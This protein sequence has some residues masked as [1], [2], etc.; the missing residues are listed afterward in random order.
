MQRLIQ[1]VYNYASNAREQYLLLKLYRNAL[2]TEVTNRVDQIRQI[3]TGNP[4]FIKLVV[5]QYRDETGS[6]YVRQ[7]L[8]GFMKDFL[9]RGSMD[10]DSDPLNVYQRW[11]NQQEAETGKASTLSR[12]ATA[13]EAMQHEPVRKGVDAAAT[14]L[15]ELSSV[16]RDAIVANLK[17][18]PYGLRYICKALQEDLK[19][20]FP[21]DGDEVIIK[22]LGVVL[23]Y[24]YFNPIIVTPERFLDD[25]KG[26]PVRIFAYTLGLA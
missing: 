15:I 8:N 9:A 19:A 1:L 23:Y 11:L 6:T 14:T 17:D 2:R 4:L 20:K 3:N 13:E 10:L 22:A 16:L 24:R 26:V 25:D 5:N 7:V 21:E 12:T 18:L